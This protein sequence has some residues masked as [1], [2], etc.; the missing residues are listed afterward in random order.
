MNRSNPIKSLHEHYYETLPVNGNIREF[1]ESTA[2]SNAK[3]NYLT[4]PSNLKKLPK[5]FALTSS[6]L[7]Y[8]ELNDSSN[9][10][11]M[12]SSN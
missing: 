12:N 1:K 6:S 5:L 8:K 9:D 3:K 2:H 10:V 7:I 11:I 4:T